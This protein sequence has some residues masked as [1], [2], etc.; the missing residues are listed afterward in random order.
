MF[1]ALVARLTGGVPAGKGNLNPQP[2]A[3]VV[4][5]LLEL[6][7]SFTLH[8][9][10][11]CRLRAVRMIGQLTASL[12]DRGQGDAVTELPTQS[13]LIERLHD[14]SAHVRAAA[15]QVLQLLQGPTQVGTGLLLQMS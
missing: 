15:V 2:L 6:S 3:D 4:P 7:L 14:K 11:V 13:K 9:T 1:L 5:A 10:E 8:H 12:L